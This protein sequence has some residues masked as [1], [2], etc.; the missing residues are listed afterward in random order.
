LPAVEVVV[1]DV[2]GTLSDLSPLAHRIVSVGGSRDLL[3]TW[4]ASVLRDGIGVAAADGYADFRALAVADLQVLLHDAGVSGDLLAA[5]EH[6][7]DGF[8]HLPVHPDVVG[9]IRLLAGAGVRL[10]TLTNGSVELTERLLGVA[11][12]LDF[13]EHRLD[14]SVPQRWKPHPGAYRHALRV[15]G[16]TADRCALIAVHPWDIDGARRVGLI[17][18]WLN[19]AGAPWPSPL[20]RPQLEAAGLEEL[21]AQLLG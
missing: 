9:G 11:G 6:V 4:F 7:V 17:G 20:I 10:V 12:V 5:A 3:Q 19:R 1:F 21:A 8:G 16:V 13:V 14:V 18:A 2:N 15:T